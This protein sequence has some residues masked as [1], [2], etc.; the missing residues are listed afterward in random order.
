MAG[1]LLFLCLFFL[2]FSLAGSVP[3]RV[4]T[5]RADSRRN[6]EVFG[7]PL[8][9]APVAP[10]PA[11]EDVRAGFVFHNVEKRVL[12]FV[13]LV[14]FLVLLVLLFVLLV[15]L[16]VLLVLFFVLLVLFFVLL[17]LLFL[18]QIRF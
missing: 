16:F 10:V 5:L 1:A 3:V 4:F 6:I 13:L 8:V 18:I 15:L 12:F 14:L 9:P 11:N 17:V 7:A 2:L